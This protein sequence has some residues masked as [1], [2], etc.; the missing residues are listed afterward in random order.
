MKKTRD[1]RTATTAMNILSSIGLNLSA[2]ER[3]NAK[4]TPNNPKRITP[5]IK[6]EMKKAVLPLID[7]L[8]GFL[9]IL[10]PTTVAIGSEINKEKRLKKRKS[11]LFINPNS[12]TA[13][14]DIAI[15]PE[16]N[17]TPSL[18]SSFTNFFIFTP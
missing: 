17:I 5:G 11:N 9:S 13:P 3:I 2:N 6:E 1:K 15:A 7:F 16:P 18:S 4:I 14:A 8:P 10:K 12:K